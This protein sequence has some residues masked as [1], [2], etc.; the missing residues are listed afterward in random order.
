MFPTIS[1]W[2]ELLHNDSID[3]VI[4][5]APV[6]IKSGFEVSAV[7]QSVDWKIMLPIT[8]SKI[9]WFILSTM[10]GFI[11]LVLLFVFSL[12][13]T[14]ERLIGI[15]SQQQHIRSSYGIFVF[16]PVL[17]NE[18]LRSIVGQASYIRTINVII[19]FTKRFL[20]IMLF[21]SSIF[22]NTVISTIPEAY[23]TSQLQHPHIVSVIRCSVQLY[24][25]KDLPLRIPLQENSIYLEALNDMILRIHGTGFSTLWTE[26]YHDDTVAA[27]YINMTSIE[28]VD[29]RKKLTLED[30]YWIW[31]MYCTGMVLSIKGEE[32]MELKKHTSSLP[33]L[34]AYPTVIWNDSTIDNFAAITNKIDMECKIGNIVVLNA[35]STKKF[36]LSNYDLK[37]LE[38]CNTIL[39]LKA[40]RPCPNKG[41][42]GETLLIVCLGTNFSTKL[43]ST[44]I[45][46]L[47]KRRNSRILFIWNTEHTATRA[48]ER[49]Q[50]QKQQELLFKY[51]AQKHL[52]NVIS[53]YRDYLYDGHFYTFSYFPE[54]HLQRKTLMQQFFPDRIKDLKGA[55]LKALPKY[56]EPLAL[57]WRNRSGQTQTGGYFSK[58]L[59]E[60]V[61]RHNAT[62]TWPIPLD[63]DARVPIP[64]WID[65]FQNDTIDVVM[66]IAPMEHITGYDVS[67]VVLLS[68]WTIMLPLP[69][70]RPDSEILLFMINS[71][72]GIVL[73]IFLFVFTL[74]FT[75][76]SFLLRRSLQKYHANWFALFLSIFFNLVLRSMIGQS[77]YMAGDT[78]RRLIYIIL[79]LS[80]ILMSTI[81]TAG[82]NSYFTSPLHYPKLNT[83]KELVDSDITIKLTQFE[84]ETLP[85][86]LS[87]E[88][89]R[90][91]NQTL[92]LP[93]ESKQLA[94]TM[95][96]RYG[97]TILTP[98]WSIIARYQT[99]LPKPL[100]YVH[101]NI[102]LIRDLP[103]CFPL[104]EHSIY[105]E[106]FNDMILLIQS[107]G[108]SDLWTKQSYDDMV[109][110]G[111]LNITTYL[112][113]VKS[114]IMDLEKL[115]YLWLVYGIGVSL[116]IVVFFAEILYYKIQTRMQVNRE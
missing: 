11:L 78:R 74:F 45:P 23:L 114:K 34:I 64:V 93:P 22:M 14:I 29:T 15:R 65:L 52:L 31:L 97:Y 67:T 24:L 108:L 12:M 54:F 60:F 48:I 41:V 6:E 109:M 37:L 2:I 46:C 87:M 92:K 107:S 21:V 62:L 44:M 66:G 68:D 72:L 63:A 17:I 75:I 103:M 99:F 43:L 88:Y 36:C 4:G 10:L 30:F 96:T 56:N 59:E 115:Y 101:E 84:Y 20:Y 50:L 110:A 5:I 16:V 116:S 85:I 105:K 71:W 57:I 8:D 104:H 28:V 112:C 51:C 76:E 98:L 73:L 106:A 55:A 40:N 18:V 35:C 7:V 86:Y 19:K 83:F 38:T 80:G 49:L 81:I 70:E 94:T 33:M 26:Q 100:F 1:Y 79:F 32:L 69:S 3:I 77:S 82:L 42:K 47:D 13:L 39:L 25:T 9:F 95:D 91:L 53:I 111:K 89:F 113:S 58:I 102:Y 61:R 27:K 90:K